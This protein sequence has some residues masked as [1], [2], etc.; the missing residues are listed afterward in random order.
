MLHAMPRAPIFKLMDAADLRCDFGRRLTRNRRTANAAIGAIAVFACLLTAWE[1]TRGEDRPHSTR[2]ATER[3]AFSDAEITE[4]FLKI[5]LGAEY[6]VAGQVDR[7]RKY[8]GPVRIY[9]DNR[10]KPDRSTQVAEAVADIRSHV[11][12]LDIAVT[13]QREEANIVVTLVRDRD[14]ERTIREFYG[15]ERARKIQRSLD[16]QCLSGIR[17]DESYRI[18]RSDV[19]L[20]VDAG[21]FVFSDCVYEELLQALGPINDVDIPWTMFNDKVQMGYF[22]IYDQYLLNILYDPRIRP[23]MS[24]EEVRAVLPQVLPDVRAFVTRANGLAP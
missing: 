21:N 19:I 16:P 15:R 20:V 12:H 13:R 22:G 7:I 6:E 3:K 14:L 17:K 2:R 8:D 23:G 9:I 18:V 11:N 24:I 10:A 1:G 5:A 4:G